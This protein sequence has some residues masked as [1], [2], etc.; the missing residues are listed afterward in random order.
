M[1][2]RVAASLAVSIVALGLVPATPAWATT[3]PCTTIT[4]TLLSTVACAGGNGSAS[5]SGGAASLT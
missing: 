3:S 5:L 4:T 2:R 1:S